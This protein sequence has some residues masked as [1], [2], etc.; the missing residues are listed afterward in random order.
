MIQALNHRKDRKKAIPWILPAVL[1]A[2]TV[3]VL[4]F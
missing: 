4:I 3:K 2:Y 1:M